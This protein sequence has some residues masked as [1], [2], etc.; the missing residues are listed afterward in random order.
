MAYKAKPLYPDLP[1]DPGHPRELDDNFKRM[2]CAGFQSVAWKICSKA[3][4]QEL[5][6]GAPRQYNNTI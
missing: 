5:K 1:K 2:G 6:D 4:V 3:M